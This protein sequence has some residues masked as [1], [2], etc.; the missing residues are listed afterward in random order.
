M[1]VATPTAAPPKPMTAEEFYELSGD[2]YKLAELVCGEV[3]EVMPSG[4]EHSE[5]GFVLGA[6]VLAHVRSARLGT[7]TKADG[8]FVLSRDPDTVRC[9]DVGFIR[10]DRLPGGRTPRGFI[11]GAP[12][13][14]VEV[15]SP[16]QYSS[17][18]LDKVR[19]YL[20][21]GTRLV[22]VIDPD[23]RVAYVYRSDMPV[24]FIREDGV[25]DGEDVLPGF[26]LPLAEVLPASADDKGGGQDG[27]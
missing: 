13:L 3:V 22:W 15:V 11:L 26:T 24:R 8:G 9:P 10:A 6:A 14:A 20:E 21:A 17:D 7:C 12:D 23:K 18:T 1:T 5:V 16:S 2:K 25:L 27:R 4:G 19:D